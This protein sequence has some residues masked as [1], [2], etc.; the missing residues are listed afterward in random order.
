MLI[1][2]VATVELDSVNFRVVREGG[3]TFR[4][5]A[6]DKRVAWTGDKAGP[7]IVR[8]PD[9]VR[10]RQQVGPVVTDETHTVGAGVVNPNTLVALVVLLGFLH[11]L[12]VVAESLLVPVTK[13]SLVF[14]DSGLVVVLVNETTE[15]L[16]SIE[17]GALPPSATPG[18]S[19]L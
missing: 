6:A 2:R 1:V 18:V 12:P 9:R 3:V 10:P 11:E 16:N 19:L 4:L 15:E 17:T 8:P 13:G 14:L 7:D 5:K